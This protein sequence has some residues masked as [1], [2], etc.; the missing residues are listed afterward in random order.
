MLALHAASPQGTHLTMERQNLLLWQKIKTALNNTIVK[1]FLNDIIRE[2]NVDVL[3][4][5]PDIGASNI[6]RARFD[7]DSLVVYKGC[8]FFVIV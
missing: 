1:K 3:F 7:F 2:V 6:I 8:Q 4:L 5:D